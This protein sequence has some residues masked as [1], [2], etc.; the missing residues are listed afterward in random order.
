MEQGMNGTSKVAWAI[1]PI[2]FLVIFLGDNGVSAGN[3][4]PA[5]T[6]EPSAWL[7]AGLGLLGVFTIC[8]RRW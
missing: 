8:R 3:L 2:L 7:L 1:I 4:G 6:P 5:I